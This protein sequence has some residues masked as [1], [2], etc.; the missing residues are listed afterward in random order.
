LANLQQN[1]LYLCFEIKMVATKILMRNMGLVAQKF[2]MRNLFAIIFT[3]LS[4]FTFSQAPKYS[5]EFLHL[6]VGADAFSMGN[7]VVAS[8]NDVGAAYWNPAGLTSVNQWLQVTA[9]HSEYFAGIAKYDHIGVAHSLGEKGVIGFTF[10]RFGV[11]DIPNTTQLI[12][13]DGRIDYDKIT[14]FSAGDYAFMGSF[15][16]KLKPVGLSVGGTAKIIHRRVG[17]FAK[18]WGFG[19]DA[20]VKYAPNEHWN[21]GLMA[22]DVTSTFNAWIFNLSPEM[23]QV[24]LTTGND[25]PANGLEL[26]LPR[27]IGGIAYNHAL[28]KAEKGFSFMTEMDFDFTTD[29]IRNVA[30]SLNPISIDPHLGVQFGYKDIVRLRGGVSSIQRS[31]NIDGVSQWGFQPNMGIGIGIKGFYLDY[32]FTKLGASD[33]SYY[34]HIFSLKFKIKQPKKKA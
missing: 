34:T 23:Q 6:G 13:N 17:D 33:A 19:L 3:G 20:G 1:T 7:A 24:F 10:L 14:T 21:F 9:M 2:T 12:D 5:N 15:A 22:R 31:S 8:T 11:D 25:L 16:K 27:F 28:G 4:V 26:S 18:S 30:I 32:A 29:G